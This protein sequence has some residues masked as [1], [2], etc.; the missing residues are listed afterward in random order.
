MLPAA[1]PN[2]ESN[3]GGALGFHQPDVHIDMSDILDEGTPWTL[4]GDD[5]GLDGNVDAFRDI[6][7]FCRVNVPHLLLAISK[8]VFGRETCVLWVV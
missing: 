6:E 5:T 1:L 3:F 2:G 4:N 7:L 8:P